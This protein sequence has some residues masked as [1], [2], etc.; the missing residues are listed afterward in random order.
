VNQNK[1]LLFLLIIFLTTWL[2][3][4]FKEIPLTPSAEFYILIIPIVLFV[5]NNVNFFKRI[6]L[7]L[8]FLLFLEI[9]F[10]FTNFYGETVSMRGFRP[11]TYLCLMALT[12]SL[13][14][15]T[16]IKKL[17]SKQFEF[18]IKFI[19]TL[20][21]VTLITSV[22]AI[23]LFPN[24][25]RELSSAS[26]DSNIRSF[27]AWFNV[28]SYDLLFNYSLISSVFLYRFM[29]DRRFLDVFVLVLIILL[30]VYAQ[31]FAAFLSLIL[32]LITTFLIIKFKINNTKKYFI[33]IFIVFIS[34]V[35]GKSFF[36][37]LSQV[38]IDNFE[39]L[40]Q[41]SMKINE[42]NDFLINKE[43]SEG[44][45]LE[46]YEQRRFESWAQFKSSP[47]FGGN[48]STGH[49]FWIDNLAKFGLIGT[50]PFI[51]YFFLFTKNLGAMV[52]GDLLKVV[53]LNSIVIFILIGFVKNIVMI[54]P[55]T[56]FFI[57]PLFI[58]YFDRNE[59]S[60]KFR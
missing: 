40:D 6:F 24:I 20:L 14:F 4:L 11:I 5:S 21:V 60:N 12:P 49:H 57:L 25:A 23:K 46:D 51:L 44:T 15:Y 38:V 19:F 1:I 31:I 56:V 47:V 43:S 18:L 3:P 42:I 52:K 54:M 13:M 35:S 58:I 22:I 48:I 37:F 9:G 26:T 53:F 41:V 33:L 32:N 7:P 34:F 29:N 45:N 16:T 30:I 55:S 10:F 36:N 27:F 2:L 59:H 39:E 28:A 50:I 17:N 8:Y